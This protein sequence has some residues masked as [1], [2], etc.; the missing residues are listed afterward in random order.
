MEFKADSSVKQVLKNGFYVAI[1]F[2]IQILTGVLFIPFL[3]KQYG[4]G[5]YGLIALAGFLTQYVGFISGCIGSSIG[6]FLNV[7]LNKNDWQAANEMFSTA[8]VAN[9]TLVLLQIPFFAWGIWKL[10]W[11]I[12]FPSEMGLDFRILV[13][14]NVAIFLSSSIKCSC[15]TLRK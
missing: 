10:D 9:V 5:T 13:A 8:L 6:R 7:S 12:D 14:C 11:V 4:T 15:S 3:V 2:G 1:R